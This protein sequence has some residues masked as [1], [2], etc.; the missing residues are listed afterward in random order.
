MNNEIKEYEL[1]EY[2]IGEFFSVG[3]DTYKVIGDYDYPSCA[4]CEFNF[5]KLC[6]S[7]ICL[8]PDR[9]DNTNVHFILFDSEE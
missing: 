7:L 9:T 5:E 3:K 6:D 4:T 8:S 2:Q 1:K